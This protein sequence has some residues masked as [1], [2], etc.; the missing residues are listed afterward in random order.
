MWPQSVIQAFLEFYS[1]SY[2]SFLAIGEI[3]V[4]T[5]LV[6]S[7]PNLSLKVT[8]CELDELK[9][10][11]VRSSLLPIYMSDEGSDMMWTAPYSGVCTDRYYCVFIC[12]SGRSLGHPI[13]GMTLLADI[14]KTFVR[15]CII[16]FRDLS[17]CWEINILT[18]SCWDKT[19]APPRCFHMNTCGGSLEKEDTSVSWIETHQA[20]IF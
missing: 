9:F 8:S 1:V 16:H 17:R 20:F 15:I 3:W 14:P 6:R 13:D 10:G 2:P 11:K 4:R 7:E 19:S 5:K 18:S 12:F